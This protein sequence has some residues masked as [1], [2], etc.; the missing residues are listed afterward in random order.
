M[1]K[2]LLRVIFPL[3]ILSAMSLV[4]LAQE[5]EEPCSSRDTV[6][7]RSAA[8]IRDEA[9]HAGDRVRKAVPWEPLEVL[10]SKHQGPWCWLEVEGGW[11]ID[12]ALV[13]SATPRDA[14]SQPQA[15][16]AGGCSAQEVLYARAATGI[17]TDASYAGSVVRFTAP[18]E[19]LELMGSANNGGRCWLQVSEGWI[20][21]TALLAS[22]APDGTN[23]TSSLASGDCYQGKVAYII[24]TMNIR[25]S[26]TT[27]SSVV[28]IARVGDV[29]IVTQSRQGEKW[30]WLKTTKG[31]LAKT[32]HV[33]SAKPVYSSGAS[34]SLASQSS[35]QSDIDN[36][37]FV[38]RQCTTEQEWK[39][40]YWAYQ[41]N[42]CG[43]PV[44]ST[45][46]VSGR[47]LIVGSATFISRLETTLDY[48][49][50]NSPTWYAYVVGGTEKITEFS[51]GVEGNCRAQAAG[52]HTEMESCIPYFG[53]SYEMQ[54]FHTAAVLAHEACHTYQQRSGR[55]FAPE[56]VEPPCQ[57]AA[58]DTIKALD[59]ERK[60]TYW[61][62]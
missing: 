37:C 3:L 14:A 19:R 51:D 11:L 18:G 30:C 62:S 38:D 46:I 24:G 43:V 17:R 7:P 36:C 1:V 16:K 25:A 61:Y 29:F 44:Q 34:P 20:L 12:S 42:Q 56:E 26:A 8:A 50:A 41:N 4:S 55:H 21:D 53:T 10:G 47:P 23:P 45:L 6:Y 49:S 31:W 40:G 59:I 5:S 39:D 32:L 60:Y 58:R 33:R 22:T 48:L 15:E 28:A 52:G 13:L 9:S 35:P 27:N 2:L 54:I 57:Q